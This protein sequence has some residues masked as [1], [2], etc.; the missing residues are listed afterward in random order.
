MVYPAV[1][2]KAEANGGNQL[3]FR[4]DWLVNAGEPLAAGLEDWS[5]RP[6]MDNMFYEP[7]LPP[8]FE[9]AVVL[10]G[11]AID[12][13]AARVASDG[14][15]LVVVAAAPMTENGSI[16]D[17]RRHFRLLE[18]LRTLTAARGIPLLD[19]GQ[20]VKDRGLDPATLHFR[21]NW[22]WSERGHEAPADMLLE[23]IANNPEV[24][25][26]REAPVLPTATGPWSGNKSEAAGCRGPEGHPRFPLAGAHSAGSSCRIVVDPGV[27]R[28][29]QQSGAV[30]LSPVRGRP[31][32]PACAGGPSVERARRGG[33]Q[34][35]VE[36]LVSTWPAAPGLGLN[37]RG[38][39]QS[40]RAVDWVG[41]VAN[42]RL[43]AA[44]AGTGAM[45]SPLCQHRRVNSPVPAAA[46]GAGAGRVGRPATTDC[47]GHAMPF[48]HHL[49]W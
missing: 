3:D 17:P 30:G 20:G 46:E 15:R 12:E 5:G 18:R 40:V 47:G 11:F 24:C 13:F 23:Y 19:Q 4:R 33:S 16:S 45:A 39:P 35:P 42:G 36:E 37:D 7:K 10:T 27:L 25:A 22:H 8:L 6:D 2:A 29:V 41:P 21:H 28:S 9:E 31:S 49:Q 48:I 34:N 38:Y 44:Y 26:Q 32:S 43:R 14:A 1:L